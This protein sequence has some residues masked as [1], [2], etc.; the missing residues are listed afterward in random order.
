MRAFEDY[1]R[2]ARGGFKH[3]SFDAGSEEASQILLQ[4]GMPP[5]MEKRLVEVFKKFDR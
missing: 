5:A 4:G 3:E 1:A 2:K